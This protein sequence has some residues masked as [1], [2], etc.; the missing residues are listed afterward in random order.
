MQPEMKRLLDDLRIT[1]RRGGAVYSDGRCVVYWMQRAQRVVDNPALN[2]AVAAGNM[3]GKPVAVFLRLL[4]APGS[5]L[6]HAQFLLEGLPEIAEGLRKR[7]IGFFVRM[8]PDDIVRFAASV[9]A[10]VIIGDENPLRESEATKARTVGG[11]EV[12]FWTVDADVIVP[13]RLLTREHYA[14]RTIRPHIHRHL[15]VFLR[16]PGHA[17]PQ[18]RWKTPKGLRSLAIDDTVLGRLG[19]DR[20]VQ[21]VGG[22]HGGTDQ[23]R[24]ALNRFVAQRLRGYARNR[25]HPELDG[26]S[27]LSPYLHFG[28]L[29]PHTVA[30][31]VSRANAPGEDKKAFLEELIVR[32]ELAVNFVR[33]NPN[34]KE[35]RSSEVWALKT[36]DEHRSDPRRVVYKE[37]QLDNA[38]T[39]DPLWN[40]AQKQMRVSG[41]MHGYLRMYWVKKILEW[42]PTP[43][44]AFDISCRLNDRY[45]LDGRDPNGYAGIAWGIGGKHDRAWGPERSVFGKIRYMSYEST[46]RKFDSKAYIDRIQQ[47]TRERGPIPGNDGG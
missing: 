7:G 14:A 15:G 28:H 32:R 46:S 3:L 26:T 30:L 9:K 41:W 44:E 5:N 42:T 43:D 18:N 16:P 12:P 29:G 20:S 4:K 6:R 34:Y 35:L 13:S 47:I 19:L 40:A 10:C 22:F 2:T 24:K 17:R 25:N 33:F 31:A 21:P 27:Q 37:S 36:L 45:E 39:H 38:E 8:Y 11:L 1:V 23:G